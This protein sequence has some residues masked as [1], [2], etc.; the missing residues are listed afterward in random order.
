M[1]C[2]TVECGLWCTTVQI[3]VKLLGVTLDQ[4]LTF[5]TQ[6]DNVVPSAMTSWNARATPYLP[7]QLLRLSYT[8][9]ICSHLE[10]CSSLHFILICC[11]LKVNHRYKEL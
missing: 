6:I 5:G 2:A 8:A 4:H 10:Y 11:P 3:S 7:K 1:D 9:L